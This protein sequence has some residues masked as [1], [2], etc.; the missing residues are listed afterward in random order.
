[1]NAS[2]RAHNRHRNRLLV[3][4]IIAAVAMAACGGGGDDDADEPDDT[5]AITADSDTGGEVTT[6]PDE[7]SSSATAPPD[8]STGGETSSLVETIPPEPS[9]VD[10]VP[11]GTGI[12][13]DGGWVP[14]LAESVTP[15]ADFKTWTLKLRDGVLFHDGT[16]V[17]ADA[18]IANFQAQYGDALVGLTIRPFF[19]ETDPV[20]KVD[21]LTVQYN[22]LDANAYYPAQ[23]ATQ[24]GMV[25]SPQWLEAAKADATLNQAPVGSGPFVFD[26]RSED[27]V[28]KFV[29]NDAWWGGEVYLDAI[30]FY[31]EPDTASRAER[32]LGD[33]FDALQTDDPETVLTLKESDGV[34]NVLDETGEEDF[35]MINTASPPFDDIRARQALAYATPL[36][37]YRQLIGLEDEGVTRAANGTFIPESPYFNPDTVQVGDDPDQALDLV[38][39]YCGEHADDVNTVLGGPACTDGKINIELQWSGPSVTQTRIAELLDSS[40]DAAGFNVTF[41]EL[42]QDEHIQQ[43]ALGQYNVNTWRQFGYDDPSLDNVWLMCRTIGGI[44]LNWPRFCDEDRDALLLQAQA[45]TDPAERASLYQQI[46]QNIV[47]AFTYI[48]FYHS[49]WD[50]AFAENVHGVCERT[51]PEGDPL[52][53]ASNGRTWFSSVWID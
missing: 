45:T 31:P 41:D 21:D 14:Y 26:S 6:P 4:P 49:I 46:D 3:L 36:A 7:S 32:L 53:C 37:D 25:A 28:T 1:M 18:V 9:D 29:R 38:A 33:E 2:R 50:N 19:P 11:G 13:P 15:S 51:S 10:P 34:N 30:E 5:T 48:F 8:D 24:I 20:I 17:N 22:L 39:A 42:L 47:D 52:K 35:A 16:P 12:T 27:S 40:W 43:T 23:L 44:S